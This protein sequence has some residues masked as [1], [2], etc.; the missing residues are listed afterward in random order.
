[1]NEPLN[2]VCANCG[3]TWGSHRADSD[4][5]DQC[6]GHEGRMDWGAGGGRTFAPTG[7]FRD[8]AYGTPARATTGERRKDGA[9]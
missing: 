9:A 3:L 5:R 7:E 4:A 1:M 2:E 6:P 8:I